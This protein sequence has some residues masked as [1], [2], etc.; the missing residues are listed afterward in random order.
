[1]KY[2]LFD[3]SG[4]LITRY[5]SEFH[6]KNIPTEATA[7]SDEVFL[8]SIQNSS[9]I[10]SFSGDKGVIKTFVDSTSEDAVST[11]RAWRNYE[12]SR[13]DIELNKVQDSDSRAVG[14]VSDWRDY[15]KALRGWPDNNNFPNNE[16]RPKAP[17]AE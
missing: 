9:F 8:D 5:D 2:I 14:S 11:E 13:S 3:P 17:D 1:M 12:L 6:G 7:V 4:K 15:R 16:F 10:F